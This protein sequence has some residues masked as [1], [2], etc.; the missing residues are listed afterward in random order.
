MPLQKNYMRERERPLNNPMTKC[1]IPTANPKNS[2]IKAQSERP[3]CISFSTPN[4]TVRTLSSS[5]PF[6]TLLLLYN[7]RTKFISRFI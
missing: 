1:G 7:L 3:E 6:F 4:A 2:L 5:I